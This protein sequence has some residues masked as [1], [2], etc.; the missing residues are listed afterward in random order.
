MTS[1]G[2]RERH[3]GQ[4]WF[5]S[6]VKEEKE[7]SHKRAWDHKKGN[8]EKGELCFHQEKLRPACMSWWSWRGSLCENCEALIGPTTGIEPEETECGCGGSM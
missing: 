4:A 5:S 3:R 7:G 2:C 6:L 8:I 1:K